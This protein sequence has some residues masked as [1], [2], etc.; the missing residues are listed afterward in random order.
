MKRILLHRNAGSIVRKT[1]FVLAFCLSLMT[2]QVDAASATWN[3]HPTN[4]E[5]NN[6]LNWMPATVPNGPADM[7]TFGLSNVTDLFL[8]ANTEVAGVVFSPGASV[9]TITASPT[10]TL[11]LSGTGIT[12]GSGITQNFVAAVDSAGHAGAITFTHNATVSTSTTLTANGSLVPNIDGAAITFLD[13]STAGAGT[14]TVNG[15]ATVAGNGGSARFYDTSS[16]GNAAVTINAGAVN[17]GNWGEVDFYDRSTAAQAT[18]MNNGPVFGELGNIG[19]FLIFHDA[20]S[21]ANAVI[22]NNGGTI[23]GAGGSFASFLDNS[24][25]GAATIKNIGGAAAGA[26]GGQTGFGDSA[27]AGHATIVSDGGAVS[28]AYG[29][30]MLFSSNST[31]GASTLIANAGPG[32]GVLVGGMIE[33]AE[34][35]EGGTA[36]V[37][38]FGNG[39][40]DIHNHNGPGLTI[41]SLEG[42][43]QI[44]LGSNN[45]SVGSNNRST[46]FSGMMHDGDPF[47]GGLAGGSLTKIG[48]GTLTLGGADTYTGPTVVSA[49]NLIVNGSITSPVTVNG[50]SLAG[51][52]T[53]RA[54]TV[55]STG[56]LTPGDSR[57][58]ILHVAGNLTLTMG[59]TYLVDLDGAAVGAQYDQTEVT[60]SVSLG[61]ATLSLKLGFSAAAGD[62]FNVINNDG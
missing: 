24:T 51:S 33:F 37:E 27:S 35:S 38:V 28:G 2:Q 5:W 40:I 30:S 10:F 17:G 46:E 15:G 29:A 55:E 7:A 4:G 23:S 1:F 16:A 3:L 48:A 42:T 56:T 21:A 45:L 6:P 61:N 31:A 20:S 59:S 12:N 39:F 22:V 36:R 47:G 57:P 13:S 41:G 60:G 19:G 8:S 58:G 50:G 18:F 25:A 32:L 14:L 11:T 62:M 54:V 53:V 34:N 26:I 52:G 9:Y 44:F 49:G 43:G